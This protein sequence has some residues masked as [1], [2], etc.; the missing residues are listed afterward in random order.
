MNEFRSGGEESTMFEY[1]VRVFEA[2]FYTRISHADHGICQQLPDLPYS[3]LP[4]SKLRVFVSVIY[5]FI[6]FVPITHAIHVRTAGDAKGGNG[7]VHYCTRRKL[8]KLFQFQFLFTFK[9]LRP[10]MH[11][12]NNNEGFDLG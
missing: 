6:E 5:W 4:H 2:V 9:F 3:Q 11:D 7:N 12:R 10:V 8:P 1:S